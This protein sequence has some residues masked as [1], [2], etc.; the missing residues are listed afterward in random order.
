M[1]RHR[2]GGVT[3]G[4]LGGAGRTTDGFERP[5]GNV[6]VYWELSPSQCFQA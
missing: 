3:V 2:G 5:L 1:I 4:G 6:N